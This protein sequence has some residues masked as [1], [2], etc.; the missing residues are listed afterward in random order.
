MSA[1]LTATTRSD[2]QI[3]CKNT[4]YAAPFA[5]P[6]EDGT[7]GVADRSLHVASRDPQRR[8][9]PP[10]RLTAE[11]PERRHAPE[12]R[13]AGA[14]SRILSRG[15][16]KRRLASLACIRQNYHHRIAK[17]RSPAPG[18]L[19]APLAPL[20]ERWLSGRKRRFAKP[21]YGLNR[22]AGSNP[23][24]SAKSFSSNE[25]RLVR[26]RKSGAPIRGCAR[27]VRFATV[28]RASRL[29]RILRL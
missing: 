27:F 14:V 7:L 21:M 5:Y 23:V 18:S 24:L 13:F 17:C 12:P 2:P 19:P 10:L 22:T 25:L 1:R 26:N 16:S 4:A 8:P 15:E 3:Y 6:S 9:P 29:R 20:P 28:R 11:S